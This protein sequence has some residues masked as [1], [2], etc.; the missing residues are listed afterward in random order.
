MA[1]RSQECDNRG[2]AKHNPWVTFASFISLSASLGACGA[3]PSHATAPNASPASNLPPLPAVAPDHAS[4]GVIVDGVRDTRFRDSPDELLT[5]PDRRLHQAAREAALAGRLYEAK[6]LLG[7][8]A[9]AYS[10]HELLVLQYN[11]VVARIEEAQATSK[12]S[13]E[14]AT[15]VTP[16]PPP[17]QYTLA[18]VARGSGGPIPKL[19]K[20]SEKANKIT[21]DEDWF[22]KNA[23]HTPA[24]FVPPDADFL[25]AGGGVTMATITGTLGGFLY[26]EL[27]PSARFLDAPLPLHVPL[28]Y[29]SMKAT[30]VIASDPYVVAIYGQRVVAVYDA[31][32]AVVGLFDFA[33]Y[34]HPPAS[35]Q[36]SLKV[37]EASLTTAGKTIQ[38]DITVATHSISHDL[39]WA[40]A[41]N[42]VLYIEHTNNTS[43]KDSRGQ[44]AYITAL[45]LGSGDMLW[46]SAPL[47]ANTHAFALV[48]G[49]VVAG[50]GFTDEP[51]LVY[52]LDGATGAIKQKIPVASGPDYAITKDGHVFV[53]TY[54]KDYVFDAK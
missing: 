10:D 8:L 2:V 4:Q 50:Y 15:L 29:G 52:V 6:R 16:A 27:T 43:A 12:A 34:A 46:R 40:M 9:A 11:A 53:R 17:A 54:N 3:K 24:Y 44:N 19:V 31:N 30:S 13:L 33:S 7:R 5:P 22:S 49:A 1:S 28:A 45:E 21:D 35:Q 39:R 48:G 41:K 32:K 20:L 42:G 36:S 23:I 18:R 14:S 51:D 38:G 26:S 47:L 37:G 25:F